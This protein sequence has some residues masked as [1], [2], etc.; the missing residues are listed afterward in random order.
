M[1]FYDYDELQD[2]V[3]SIAAEGDKAIWLDIE[4][5]KNALKRIA[6]RKLFFQALEKMRI[7]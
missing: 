1:T 6:K 5:E 4:T 7:K 3:A 2:M